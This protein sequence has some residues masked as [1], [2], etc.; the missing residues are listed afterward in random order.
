MAIPARK[1][2]LCAV[3]A[4]PPVDITMLNRAE[5]MGVNWDAVHVAGDRGK[6]VRLPEMRGRVWR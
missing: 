6:A 5:I 1:P 3:P 4:D 2:Q